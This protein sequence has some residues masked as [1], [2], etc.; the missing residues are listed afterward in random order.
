[1]N[2]NQREFL[3]RYLVDRRGTNCLKWDALEER[4]GDP[5]LIS[6]WVA[7]MEIKTDDHI[8][9]ALHGRVEQGV[10]GYTFPWD[11]YY[12]AFFDWMESRHGYRPQKEWVRFSNGVVAALYWFVNAF[13]EP[14]DS[15]LILT[16]VYYPFRQAI[17]KTGRNLV[18]VDL[19]NTQGYFIMDYEAIERAIEEN[20]VK[21]FIQ[22]S[23]HNPVGRVWTEEELDRVMDICYRHGVLIVSD[24][25]HQ[26]IIVGDQKQ[27]PA[28]LV[29]GGK[30]VDRLIS[31]SAASKTFN[32]AGLNHSNIVIPD[33]ELRETYDRYVETVHQAEANLL[34]MTATEAGYRFGAPWL[35]HVLQLIRSNDQLLRN[36]LNSEAPG[37]VIS[38]LEGTYLALLDLRSYVQ[39]E[40]TKEFIQDRCRLAVDFG[41]WFGKNFQGFVRLNLATDPRYVEQAA[42]N[43]VREVGK[44]PL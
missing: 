6:M 16:P 15:C 33:R 35:D 31:V 38:P 28:A 23:P 24:E 43:I 2:M 14:G 7:D 19:I 12:E 40:S 5:D 36:R 22:C 1:M 20:H 9:E 34:G 17:Q 8:V 4:Y 29:A 30:Y 18:S 3:E 26:D 11:S 32:L 10:Y 41:E 37:I 42:E 44:L 27:I 39:P 13:T 21:L 25:I